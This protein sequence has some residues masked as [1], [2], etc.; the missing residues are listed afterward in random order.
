MLKLYKKFRPI[1]WVQTFLI[2]GLTI[3]QVWCT[4]LLVDY[5]QDITKSIIFLNYQNQISSILPPG[6]SIGD[7]KFEQILQIM[8]QNL[9]SMDSSKLTAEMW[10]SIQTATTGDIWFNGGM[11]V[12]VA[13]GAAGCQFVIAVLAAYISSNFATTLRTE[14]NTKIS[15]F[16]LAE[17]NKFSTA[18]L[19]TRATNDVQQVQMANL[20]VMRM[21][22]AAPVTAIWA[23]CKVQASSWQLTIAAAV[24]IVFLVICIIILMTFVMP[25]FKIMQK[26]IDKV[27]AVTGENLTG[28]RVVRAYNA[29]D[30]QESKFEKAN[31]DLTKT[32][33]FTGRMLGLMSPI[34]TLVMNGLTL[35]VYWIGA[36]LI[37]GNEIDYATVQAFTMLCTQIVMAFLMLMMMFILLPRANVCAKRIQEV[38][39]TEVSVK[40]PEVEKPLVKGEEGTITFDHVSFAYPD[41]EADILQDISFTAKKGQ[42]IAFIGSTGS[43][44]STLVNLV[45][46]FYDVTKGSITIDGV[47]VRNMKQSTL[48]GLVGFVPQKGLLFSGT[49]KSNIK[50]G[51]SNA[52]DKDVEQACKIA[53][54]DEFISKMEKD[55]IRLSLVVEQMSQVVKDKDFVSLELLLQNLNS[56]SSMT[57]SQPWISRQINKSER[58]WLSLKKMLLN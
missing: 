39:D 27:N 33:L 55:T 1:D 3:V 31:K 12:L 30:Y 52:S 2:I 44:K 19:V 38:I 51:N 17:I 11:M 34:M 25:K 50:F 9:G 47:D 10:T 36:G 49:I 15:N 26:F 16:S 23:I 35:A 24:G 53:C 7:I 46:R 4:M 20:L 22:F 5:V 14:V 13:T 43:G 48:R 45:T 32:Q 42:T 28:I 41:A 18:S 56:S 21:V 57:L 58:T 37:A 29:E 40:D 6:M 8:T 54:A